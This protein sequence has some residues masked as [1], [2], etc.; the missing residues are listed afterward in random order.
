MRQTENA[1]TILWPQDLGRRYNKNPS[2]I[3]HWT[4]DGRLPPHDVQIGT[5]RGW[6][7]TTIE[8]HER[9]QPEATDKAA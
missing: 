1:P 8:R 6:Y 7:A 4:R 3:W 5:R 9:I 2:T